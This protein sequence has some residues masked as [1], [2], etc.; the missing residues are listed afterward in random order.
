MDKA[1]FI[2]R[3]PIYYALAIARRLFKVNGS[4]SRNVIARAY[5][6]ENDES[7]IPNDTY[8][9]LHSNALWKRAIKWLVERDLIAVE[10]DPFGPSVF[11]KTENFGANWLTLRA[12]EPLIAKFVALDDGDEWLRDTLRSIFD[13]YQELGIQE[14]DFDNPDEEWSPIQLDSADPDVEKVVDTLSETVE[15]IRQDNGYSAAHPQERDFVL[16]GLNGTLEKFK[17]STVSAGYIRVALERLR[18]VARRFGG[19][20][21]ESVIAGATQALIEFAK[22]NAIKILDSLLNIF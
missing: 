18:T 1:D 8:N 15:A 2:E 3:A 19:T 5:E 11:A 16:E 14:S 17:S 6:V 12:T 9:L 10:A 4:M 7:H 13:R 20:V 22:K 21:K